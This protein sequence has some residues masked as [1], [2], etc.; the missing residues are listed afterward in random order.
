MGVPDHL[1]CLLR[2]VYVGQE[3]TELDI[4][5]WTCSKLGKEYIEA[6]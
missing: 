2:S 3:E 6:V 5:Q 1:S 4:K